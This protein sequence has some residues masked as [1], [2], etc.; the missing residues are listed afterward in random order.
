MFKCNIA[1]ELGQ[2]QVE[3]QRWSFIVCKI[4]CLWENVT[5]FRNLGRYNLFTY[6]EFFLWFKDVCLWRWDW[7]HSHVSAQLEDGSPSMMR[8][9]M[10][11]LA[12]VFHFKVHADRWI[13]IISEN[14][15]F[16][17]LGI[18]NNKIQYSAFQMHI[19][20]NEFY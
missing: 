4:L 7:Y 15:D 18:N 17:F 19:Y 10:W 13:V 12:E 2:D 20:P 14:L 3:V 5:I 11:K 6:Q 8:K 9:A 16:F 1:S